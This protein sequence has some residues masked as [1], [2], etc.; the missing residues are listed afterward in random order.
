MGVHLVQS[1]GCKRLEVVA[2]HYWYAPDI[3]DEDRNGKTGDGIHGRG[4]LV[5]GGEARVENQGPYL[6]W[7]NVVGGD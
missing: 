3:V 6:A 4:D 2:G 7:W 1:E 5:M